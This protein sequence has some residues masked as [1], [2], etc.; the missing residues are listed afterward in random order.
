MTRIR[1][2]YEARCASKRRAQQDIVEHLP[3]LYE[4]ACRYE[5]VRVIELGVRRG[6][7]TS[8]FLAAAYERDG[9]VWSC[10]F[11]RPLVP[12]WWHDLDR[13]TF[14]QGDDR[15]KG[16]RV[17]AP[18]GCDVLF[19]DTSHTYP[20]TK[21]ELRAYG[22]RVCPGGVILCHDTDMGGVSRA[23]DELYPEWVYR[24]GC[25]GLG[26]VEVPE[27]PSFSEVVEAFDAT[28]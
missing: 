7:S 2:D 20:H 24:L 11:K 13:W 18:S 28:S 10:D 3:F 21:E 4:T 16:A 19:I 9:Q 5:G 6:N 15:P 17:V 22:P 8:A 27:D 25:N 1:A 26:V 12:Q 14:Y 23:L